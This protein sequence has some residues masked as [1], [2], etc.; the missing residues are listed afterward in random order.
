MPTPIGGPATWLQ[1][2]LIA[3]TE[4]SR[5]ALADPHRT[6]QTAPSPSV[7]RVC[8]EIWH[9]PGSTSSSG[10]SVIGNGEAGIG[11][12]RVALGGIRVAFGAGF[13]VGVIAFTG[14][15]N[16][17][18]FVPLA[19]TSSGRMTPVRTTMRY[20]GEGVTRSIAIELSLAKY[21][22]GV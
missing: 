9:A 16:T 22:A 12:V 4:T 17:P 2:C 6:V 19:T 8:A 13:G 20:P 18:S 14:I 21:V 3:A 11:G 10:R 15:A 5:F 1:P 7:C